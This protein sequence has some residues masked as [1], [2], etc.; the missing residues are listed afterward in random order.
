MIQEIISTSDAWAK[1]FTNNR[2]KFEWVDS[3]KWLRA[4]KES[5]HYNWVHPYSILQKESINSGKIGQELITF[6]DTQLNIDGVDAFLFIYPKGITTIKDSINYRAGQIQTKRGIISA[7]VYASSENLNRYYSGQSFAMFL[8]HEH[9]HGFGY[10]G[11]SPA[12]PPL[13]S[14]SH[15][16]G[17][18]K[19]MHAW[20]RLDLDWVTENDLYCNSLSNISSEEITL[21]PQE[22]EQSGFKAAAIKLDETRLIVIESHRRDKWSSDFYPGF[23]GLT[24]MLVDTTR[25]TDRRGEGSGDNYRGTRYSRTAT[26]FQF[27]QY[28]TDREVLGTTRFEGNYLLKKGQS[29]EIENLKIS[30]LESDYNDKIVLSK[31]TA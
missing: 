2:L 3:Q 25:D 28:P 14:I 17:P 27:T 26:Y 20:D 10:I 9:M 6:T 1:W 15:T 12:W 18:S 30:F 8:L 21:V 13:F 16:G 22:R 23:Y 5:S 7:G 29:F 24:V 4:P 31:I 11:H 19:T